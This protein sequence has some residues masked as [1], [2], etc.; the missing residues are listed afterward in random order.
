MRK[1]SLLY[2]HWIYCANVIKG[3]VAFAYHCQH[4]DKL[5]LSYLAFVNNASTCTQ[6]IVSMGAVPL[7]VDIHVFW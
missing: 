3:K 4:Q 1:K 2:E 7:P 5:H 6:I